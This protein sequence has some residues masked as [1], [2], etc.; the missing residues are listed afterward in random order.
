M[1]ILGMIGSGNFGNIFAIKLKNKE[2]LFAMK[3]YGKQ[4]FLLTNLARFLFSEKRIMVNF[5]HPFLVKMHYAFQNNE[6]LFIIMDYCEKGD[7]GNQATRLNNLQLKILTCELILA[8]KALHDHD[9]I[10]RDLKPNNVFISEDGHIKL[11]DFGLSK[12]NV[13]K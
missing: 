10:H 9:I 5:E 1:K 12:E 7:L 4:E 13:I 8:I 6:K 2:Q 11:G 3:T